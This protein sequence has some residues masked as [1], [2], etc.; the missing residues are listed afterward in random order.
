MQN[1]TEAQIT[2]LLP[3][4]RSSRKRVEFAQSTL[5]EI[6]AKLNRAGTLSALDAKR[7]SNASLTIR[8]FN[9]TGKVL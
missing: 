1:V 2:R 6:N 8:H 9:Q 5:N 4:E 7:R 3:A